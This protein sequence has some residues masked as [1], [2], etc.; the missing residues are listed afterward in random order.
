VRNDDIVVTILRPG[1]TEHSQVCLRFSP[2]NRVELQAVGP[3]AIHVCGTYDP[4]NEEDSEEEEIGDALN[5]M[6]LAQQ[7]LK[8]LGQSSPS[9]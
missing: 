5:E 6:E 4:L 3:N 2:L 7:V 1:L 8:L 9:H